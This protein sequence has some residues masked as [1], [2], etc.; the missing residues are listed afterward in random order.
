MVQNEE[1]EKLQK[2]YRVVSEERDIYLKKLNAMQGELD[3]V[4]L[5]LEQKVDEFELLEREYKKL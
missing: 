2:K 3:E 4:R 1:Y 5:R